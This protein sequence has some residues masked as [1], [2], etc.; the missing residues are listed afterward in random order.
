MSTELIRDNMNI[1][2]TFSEGIHND[3]LEGFVEM[4]GQSS[5]AS[6]LSRE[7]VT[8]VLYEEK[9]REE[10]PCNKSI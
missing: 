3:S 6:P 8:I 9:R 10:K 7:P 1:F 2:R 4:T 5:Q